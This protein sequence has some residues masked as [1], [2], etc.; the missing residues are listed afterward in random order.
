V[1]RKLESGRS[2]FPEAVEIERECV[3]S[4]RQRREGVGALRVGRSRLR[5]DENRAREGNG[6]ASQNGAAAIQRS[7]P[8]ISGLQGLGP[9]DRG[10]QREG[11]EHDDTRSLHCTLLRSTA[12]RGDRDRLLGGSC[13]AAL[14][15][16]KQ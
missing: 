5:C 3:G 1:S 10:D 14:Y 16:A 2:K 4:R 7:A 11:K 8:D 13:I 9:E 15:A 12:Y 6:A